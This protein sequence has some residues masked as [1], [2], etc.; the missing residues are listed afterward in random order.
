MDQRY[1]LPTQNDMQ[2]NI[3]KPSLS[4]PRLVWGLV[5]DGIPWLTW[6]IIGVL[7]WAPLCGATSF[8]T[9]VDEAKGAADVLGLGDRCDGPR[10][11]EL[12]RNRSGNFRILVVN[13]G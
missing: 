5:K 8:D 13:N 6:L 9:S 11:V 10:H 3:K 7:T 12:L 2:K 4:E 1:I